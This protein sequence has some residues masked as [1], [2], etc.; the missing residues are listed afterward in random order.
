MEGN[1]ENLK[2]WEPG[3]VDPPFILRRTLYYLQRNY[4]EGHCIPEILCV[5]MTVME[6][7]SLYLSE[8]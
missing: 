3:N 4:L 8:N 2:N 5:V 6:A 1:D 7:I